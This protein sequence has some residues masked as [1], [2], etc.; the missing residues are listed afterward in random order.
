HSLLPRRRS[1]LAL[2]AVA[3]LPNSLVVVAGDHGEGLG[4]HGEAT[5]SVF[6]YESTLHVPLLL[7]WPG[8]WKPR[9]ID[10]T[11]RLLDLAPTILEAGGLPMLPGSEGSSLLASVA[12]GRIESPRAT[13]LRS[14]CHCVI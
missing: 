5:H 3:L 7:W 6:L 2:C 8:H 4:E 10:G 1:H 11:P 12:T 9:V 14:M 13:Y